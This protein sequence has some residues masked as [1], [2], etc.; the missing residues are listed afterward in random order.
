ME[1]EKNESVQRKF[2]YTPKSALTNQWS[3]LAFSM[4]MI[5]VPLI[6]P[7]GLRIRRAYILSPGV[8]SAILI[9]AGALLLAKTI[10]DIRK[11]KVLAMQ[12]GQIIVDG[13]RVVYPVVKKGKIEYD[14]FLLSDVQ[15]I[16][17]DED[18]SQFDVDLP[19]KYIIFEIKYF[20]SQDK[21]D[22]FRALFE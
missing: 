14:S 15:E 6:Y 2:E 9:I 16:K 19:D 7:F 22:E 11:A 1:T 20:D 21:F 8:F 18:E 5:I 13:G 3:S 12:G 4:G 10:Y 17:D